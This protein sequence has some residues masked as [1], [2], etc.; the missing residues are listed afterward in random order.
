M[1]LEK[2]LQPQ[3]LVVMGVFNYTNVPAGRAVYL[4]TN[5]PEDVWNILILIQEINKP[6]RESALLHVVLTNKKVLVEDMKVSWFELE[7]N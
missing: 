7:Q 3:T 2:V 6:I 4:G 5:K 1:Q